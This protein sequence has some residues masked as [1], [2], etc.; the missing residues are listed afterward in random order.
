MSHFAN[1][2]FLTFLLGISSI[3]VAPIFWPFE[4][5]FKIFKLSSPGVS[6]NFLKQA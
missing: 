2:F 3:S 1:V 6:L 5:D 4:P